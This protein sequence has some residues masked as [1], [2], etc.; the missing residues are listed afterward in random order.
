MNLIL[1]FFGRIVRSKSPSCVL[2]LKP[3]SPV[4]GLGGRLKVVGQN[5]QLGFAMLLRNRKYLNL[6]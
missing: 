4:T 2:V 3:C 5:I 6:R 1:S